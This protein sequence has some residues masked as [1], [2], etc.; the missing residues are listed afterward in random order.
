M[1]SSTWLHVSDAMRLIWGLQPASVLDVGCGFGRWGFLCRELLDVFKGRIE[2][3]AWKTR[4]DA[5]EVFGG[6]INEIH[7]K[8]Y[9]SIFVADMR[10][11]LDAC[12]AKYDLM[13]FGD[14][15]EHLPKA[16]AVGVLLRAKKIAKRILIGIPL[17]D[18][19]QQGECFGNTHEAHVSTWE[20][21]DFMNGELKSNGMITYTDF[22]NRPYALVDLQGREDE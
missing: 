21:Q 16:D 7:A 17:G 4:I 18:K 1:P 10:D 22:K 9:D 5:V 14:V 2:K 13:I 11:F 3:D 8:L 19:W 20:R 6:Y 12:H 15:L